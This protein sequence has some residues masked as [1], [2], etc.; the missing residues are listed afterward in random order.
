MY[1][2]N[3]LTLSDLIENN[4]IE[5]LDKF[6]FELSDNAIKNITVSKV[7]RAINLSNDVATKILMRCREEGLLTISYGIRCP[8]CNMLIKRIEDINDVPDGELI[9]YSCESGVQ[10][11]ARDIEVLFSLTDDP[12]FNLGQQETNIQESPA[13]PVAPGDSLENLLRAGNSLN[14]IFFSPTDLEYLELKKMFNSIFESTKTT[15]ERGDTLED[16]I[17]YLFN[18]SLNLNASGIRTTT[19]QIDCFVRNKVYLPYGIFNSIGGQF[20]IECK[21]EKKTPHGDYMSKLH[22]IIMTANG[23]GDH[24]KFGIIASKIPG[25]KTFRDLANKYYLSNKII[26]IAI[27]GDEIRDLVDNKCNLFELIERKINEI[28][29]DSTTDLKLAGLYDV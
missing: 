7:S 27:C 18:L 22:S 9:C 8:E 20:V 24:I 29:L 21:N 25:P 17:I 1:Y 10:I 6:F 16:L 12:L 23:K 28:I 11:S 2:S 15:K 3:L 4:K 26:V 13:S 5:Q 14:S 19:N